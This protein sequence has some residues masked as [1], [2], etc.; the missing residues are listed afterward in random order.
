MILPSEPIKRQK[1]K[2]K[3][4]FQDHWKEFW[5]SSKKKYPKDMHDSI[6]EAVEKMSGCGE[7]ENGYA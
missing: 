4:I 3:A 6:K 7:Y 1:V 2:I 5:K